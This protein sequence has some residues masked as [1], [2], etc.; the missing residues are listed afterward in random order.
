M[1]AVWN[2]D[3]NYVH[4]VF[5]CLMGF[6]HF[7]EDSLRRC[8]HERMCLLQHIHRSVSAYQLVYNRDSR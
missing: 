5:F 6:L 2:E 7:E 3:N 4:H 1:P 8:A